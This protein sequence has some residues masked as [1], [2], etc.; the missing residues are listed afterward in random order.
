MTSRRLN[1][2]ALTFGIFCA[3]GCSGV[4]AFQQHLYLIVH[5][6]FAAMFFFSGVIYINM[7]AYMESWRD[8]RTVAWKVRRCVA[9][10]SVLVGAGGTAL[11]RLLP[12]A[13]SPPCRC[14][15]GASHEL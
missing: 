15:R 2:I 14:G 12:R 7:I 1:R 3:V 10:L 8:E 5:L 11:F 9:F 6:V 13:L 4:A